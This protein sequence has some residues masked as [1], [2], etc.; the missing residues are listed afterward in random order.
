MTEDSRRAH[1]DGPTL[2]KQS[3]D[4]DE[5]ASFRNRKYSMGMD[6]SFHV[7]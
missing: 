5:K 3:P 6:W 2:R 4:R 7:F 1:A